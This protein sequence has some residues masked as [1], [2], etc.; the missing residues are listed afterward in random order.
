MIAVIALA[1]K[2]GGS[3]MTPRENG[4]VS[5]HECRRER[6]VGKQQGDRR[7]HAGDHADEAQSAQRRH[8][9]DGPSSDMVRPCRVVRGAPR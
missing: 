6:E 8:H 4:E 3:M 2:A 5:E 7:A 1:M 9:A